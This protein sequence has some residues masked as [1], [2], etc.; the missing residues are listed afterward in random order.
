MGGWTM[1][2]I[3][4]MAAFVVNTGLEAIPRETVHFSKFLIVKIVASMM[5]GSRTQSAK[6]LVEFIEDK[7]E[8]ARNAALIG[9]G[10]RASLED[11]AFAN[12]LFAHAAE[13]E[14]D[15]F[16]SSTSDITVVPVVF[17]MVE[18]FHL[19]GKAV[20]E[21]TILGQ[22]VMNR[23]GM[24]PLASKG[25]V[26][27]PFYGTLGACI[28]AAKALGLSQEQLKG[29]VGIAMGRSSG[30]VT[31]F[32]TD[33]HY[34]ESALACRDGMLASLLA[35]HGMSGNP[36]I[37][38]WLANLI[39]AGIS[40]QQ[41][42]VQDLGKAWRIHNVWIKKY[43]C[44]FITHR[45]IDILFDLR[46]KHSFRP[47]DVEDLTI[48]DGPIS[49]ICDRPSPSH[50]DD[51][52]FSFQHSVAAALLDGDVDSRHFDMTTI[53]EP[54]FVETRPKVRVVIHDDWPRAFLS[55][56]CRLSV[57]LKN[58]SELSG[59]META[60]GSPALPIDESRVSDLF[61]K[62]MAGLMKEEDIRW[63]W[64]TI[65]SLEKMDDLRPLMDRISKLQSA[66][67]ETV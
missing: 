55:G 46:R 58:G 59:E 22:E 56:V 5:R 30:L 11:A 4:K 1:P 10:L 31:N 52:R 15:Q 40:E 19:N 60:V 7:K 29:A 66:G 13:L 28:T 44:C 32:G 43:P 2:I 20:L 54:R 61:S 38:T 41:E 42:I 12:G 67:A 16:P 14:D 45:P 6:R 9:T 8:S 63:L 25:F 34:I 33:G 50:T 3:D 23:V 17:S 64:E 65:M 57:R 51:A 24:Y 48:H 27:L 62:I 18:Q 53:S 47:E 36:D 35:L 37:E 49:K 21:A 26:E 39:G